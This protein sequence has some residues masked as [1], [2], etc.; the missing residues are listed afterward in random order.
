MIDFI[1]FLIVGAFSVLAISLPIIFLLTGHLNIV[2]ILFTLLPFLF[3]I[4]VVYVVG[5][6]RQS[7]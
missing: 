3:I 2:T 1:K 5:S 7:N 6:I 4:I